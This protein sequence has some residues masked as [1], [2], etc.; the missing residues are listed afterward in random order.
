VSG[1]GGVGDKSRI[2]VK[3]FLGEVEGRGEMFCGDYV[4]KEFSR[5]W[6]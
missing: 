2:E 4:S 5:S 3:V 1:A 6:R